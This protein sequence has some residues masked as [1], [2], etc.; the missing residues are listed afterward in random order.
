MLDDFRP[1]TT[2]HICHLKV[3]W[4]SEGV[5]QK[6]LTLKLTL[7]GAKE[8]HNYLMLECGERGKGKYDV[9]AKGGE[10]MTFIP[11]LLPW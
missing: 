1:E 3:E 2:L 10:S 5:V 7:K 9:F 6:P 11:P 8:P 4:D